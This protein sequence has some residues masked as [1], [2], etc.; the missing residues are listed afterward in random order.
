MCFGQLLDSA[1][2]GSCLESLQAGPITPLSETN[3]G[4][5][6]G[7]W[8]VFHYHCL[9]FCFM[10]PNDTCIIWHIVH[11]NWPTPSAFVLRRCLQGICGGLIRGASWSH[12]LGMCS[13][14]GT[15][16][17]PQQTLWLQAGHR[18]ILE[19]TF[20]KTCHVSLSKQFDNLRC[21]KGCRALVTPGECCS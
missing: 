15:R 13:F 17:Q 19:K 8:D 2:A 16:L 6:L 14:W 4:K 20:W 18:C 21:L 7:A 1:V 11:G 12:C 9:S 10:T 5:I 3:G